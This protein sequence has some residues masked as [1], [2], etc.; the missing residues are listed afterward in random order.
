MRYELEFYDEPQSG[1]EPVR[2]WLDRL[3]PVKRA[4]AMRALSI[5]LAGEGPG[6]CSTEY[7][8]NLGGGLCEFRL[9]HD[10]DEVLRARRPDLY[11]KLGPQPQGRVLLRMFFAEVDGTVILLLGGYDKGRDPAR[12]RQDAEIRT[13]RARLAEYRGRR[14]GAS[15]YRFRFVGWWVEQVRRQRRS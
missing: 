1:R 5:I 2:D 14:G 4:A 10:A 3:D 7:G 15:R 6:V 11:E 9:R 13:A 12:R 8:K